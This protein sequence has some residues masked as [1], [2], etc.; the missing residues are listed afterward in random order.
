MSNVNTLV[1]CKDEYKDE[2]DFEEAIKTAVMLLLQNDY[3]MT[4]RY[5]EKG[6]GIVAIEYES[7]NIEYGG[8]MPYWLLPEDIENFNSYLVSRGDDKN[9]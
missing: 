4:I 1:I 3:V 2:Y 9:E 8:V 6:F 5:D 7:N